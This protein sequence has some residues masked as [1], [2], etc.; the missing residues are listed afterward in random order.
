MAFIVIL[1]ACLFLTLA[2]ALN[3]SCAP[4]G[5]FDL[6]IWTLQLP[7]GTQGKVTQIS[8][9]QLEGCSGF[10]DQYFYTGTTDGSLI[11][12]VPGSPATAGCVTT[13]G[14]THCRTE[15]RES[16]S[17]DPNG[18]ANRLEATVV[19]VEADNGT[20]GTVIGQIHMDDSVSSKPVCELFYASSG[21][22][23]MGVEQTIAGGNEVTTV[24]GNVP[25]GTKFVYAIT[26]EN[27]ILSVSINN[28][29][30]QVL[31]TFDLDAPLS[32]FKAGNYNQ[33]GTPSEVHFFEIAVSHDT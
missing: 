3:S 19:V 17:W 31:S 2:A 4:G 21:K 24:V 7:T 14:S 13:S 5:N 23:V 12:T 27:N 8:S 15:L 22:I 11:T 9:A 26:Y 10:Q 1:K 25:L 29:A 28:G 33:G 6:S 20:H 16:T 30:P 32:Y 18:P